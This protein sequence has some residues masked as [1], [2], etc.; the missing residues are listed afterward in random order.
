MTPDDLA[1]KDFVMS[2]FNQNWAVD[3][4]GPD[5]VVAEFLDDCDDV[6]ALTA[7]ARGIDALLCQRL[8]DLD[9]STRL[10]GEYECYYDP[11]GTGQS[12]NEWLREI[13]AR[14]GR[15]IR[16]RETMTVA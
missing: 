16:R 5:E 3:A 8:P 4:S 9:L 2:Y 12:T 6:G 14:L 10:S 1:F 15:E 13:R 7:V 11:L